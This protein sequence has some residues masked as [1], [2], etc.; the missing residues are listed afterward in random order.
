MIGEVTPFFRKQPGHC[1]LRSRDAA[2]ARNLADTARQRI[3]VADLEDL[4]LHRLTG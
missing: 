1:N 4:Q 3:Q 2:R